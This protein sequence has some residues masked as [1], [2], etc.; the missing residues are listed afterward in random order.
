M[1]NHQVLDLVRSVNV[2]GLKLLATVGVHPTRCGEVV[3][4]TTPSE[5]CALIQAGADVVGAVGE[6]GLD[7]ER[8]KFCPVEVQV[9]G[10]ELMLSEV[11]LK[12]PELPLFLHFRETESEQQTFSEVEL[13]CKILS[14]HLTDLDSRGHIFAGAVVHSFTGT[15]SVA[16]RILS[17]HPDIYIG[18]NGCSLRRASL[19]QLDFLRS[20]PADRLLFETD[21][22]YCDIRPT[23][24]GYSL[25]DKPVKYSKKWSPT[26][27]LKGRNEPCNVA[28]VAE[29][30]NRFLGRDRTEAVYCNSLR[31]FKKFAE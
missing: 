15:A 23:H 27:L 13:F 7:F 2:P 5:L 8:T 31:L 6:I 24:P 30:V 4:D 29:V 11:A 1:F 3:R 18:V 19:E 21:A 10:F 25:L 12:F 20:I 22:P 16:L 9:A 26:D 14:K 17:L 28:Q